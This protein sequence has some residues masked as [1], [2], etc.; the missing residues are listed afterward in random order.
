MSP[1]IITNRGCIKF[2]GMAEEILILSRYYR[3]TNASKAYGIL[4]IQ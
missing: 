1:R 4:S 2:E 3:K